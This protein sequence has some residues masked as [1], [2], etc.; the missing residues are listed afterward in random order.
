MIRVGNEISGIS[1]IGHTK[2]REAFKKSKLLFD[3]KY[4]G[5]FQW[6][7]MIFLYEWG[8]RVL[9]THP[10]HLPCMEKNKNKMV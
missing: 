2:L 5:L 9:E 3:P 6:E 8:G 1:M 7:R 10:P 4:F